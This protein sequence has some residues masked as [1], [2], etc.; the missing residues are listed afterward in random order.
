VL[1]DHVAKSRRPLVVVE[2]R[3]GLCTGCHVR[4]RPQVFNEVR[5]NDSLIQCDSCLRI[6]YF[7]PAAARV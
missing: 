4:L 5:R 7:V 6:L 2:A 1:F 3:D